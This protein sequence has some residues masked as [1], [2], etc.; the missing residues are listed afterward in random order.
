MRYKKRQLSTGPNSIIKKLNNYL[1]SKKI[2]RIYQLTTKER[3][4][5]TR[6]KH[7]III[8]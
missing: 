1:S 4:N 7:D 8:I 3:L 5:R 2:R 6:A